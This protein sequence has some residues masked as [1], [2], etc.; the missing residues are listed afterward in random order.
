MSTKIT[1]WRL[2]MAGN[3]DSVMAKY[4]S[5]ADKLSGKFSNLQNKISSSK[6]KQFSQDFSNEI[7][8]MSR[9]MSLMGSTGMLLG[10]G[11]T[12]V[13]AGLYK[14]AEL[15]L[16]YEK[17]MAKINATTQLTAPELA[18]LKTELIAVGEHSGGNFERIPQAFEKINSTINDSAK[19]MAILKI[20]NKGAQAGF[21]DI[22]VAAGA[23]AQTISILGSKASAADIMDTMLGAKK[24]G[25][26][27]FQDFANYLPS[28]IAAG[29]N[30]GIGYKDIAGAF[31][32]MTTNFNG[33][34]AA[35]YMQNAMTAFGKSAVTKGLKE[36][37]IDVFNKDG[38]M[39]ALDAI[40]IDLGAKINTMT[41][42]G[43]SAFLESVGLKDAQAKVA[44]SAMATNADKLRK[45]MG[46][47]N[48]SAGELGKTLEATANRSR[49]WGDIGDQ[50]KSWG[51][52][53]G[54]FLLPMIDTLTNRIE[55]AWGMMQNM[56]K[57]TTYQG[58]GDKE[59]FESKKAMALQTSNTEAEKSFKTKY[60]FDATDKTKQLTTEH[61]TFLASKAGQLYSKIMGEEYQQ[62]YFPKDTAKKVEGIFDDPEE[63]AAKKG[64][65]SNSHIKSGI[66]GISGG[67]KMVRNVTVNFNKALIEKFEIKATTV[68]E[69]GAELVRNIEDLLLR[70]VNGAELSLTNE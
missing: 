20:A 62:K 9:G 3:V 27:E 19:S 16:S 32:F 12:A 14:S 35:M 66:D 39:R 31:S 56:F 7:P 40:F 36:K 24:S 61:T 34:D 57:K 23:L 64:K 43:K 45:I 4:G 47:V 6:F 50:I 8:V 17:G 15:A 63:K 60:G 38:S 37:G 1:E 55:H 11:I 25:A 46:E 59:Q 29:K 41:D 18:K 42:Q 68:K 2:K 70:A 21:V 13:G 49:S 54:D 28:L 65:S 33:A 58:F 44:F 48:N 5:G 53:I 30:I 51:V 52:S 22:D 69:S 67:G 10:A 26:A